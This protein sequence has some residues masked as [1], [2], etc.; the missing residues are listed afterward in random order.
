ML[1]S[2]PEVAGL[3]AGSQSPHV[4]GACDLIY[5]DPSFNSNA[6]YNILVREP[7]GIGQPQGAQ[8]EVFRDTSKS[9]ICGA[10]AAFCGP[11]DKLA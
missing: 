5:L 11:Q 1:R 9:R 10:M 7:S 2:P 3:L 4:A 8:S 6:S